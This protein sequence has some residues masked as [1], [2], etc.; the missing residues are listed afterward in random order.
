MLEIKNL[1]F[2]YHKGEA[3]LKDV[4]LT[5]PE[6][7]I[8]VVLGKNGSGKSTLFKNLVGVLNPL[9]GE[10]ILNKLK[11]NEL[12]RRKRAQL[13]SYV[14]Q[15]ISFTSLSVFDS[16][17]LGRIASFGIAS[18]KNDLAI[19]EDIINEMGLSPLA[20]RD[21]S[22]LSGGEAQKVAIARS[23]ALSPS[24]LVFDEPT[25]ALDIG[26]ER[27]ILKEAQKI[28]RHRNLN[29][30]M[31]VHDI[32]LALEYGEIFYFI[33][34]GQLIYQCLRDE[35]T[36]DMINDTFDI[37]AQIVDVMGKKFV[38]LKDEIVNE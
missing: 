33:K 7:M 16:I 21:A 3:V 37:N 5:L 19:V 6:G 30:L 22:S 12:S 13:V 32:N 1:C 25:G 24:L 15:N 18:T 26:N 14:P 20:N 9:K 36:V 34:D 35:V 27:L 28:V 29:I 31:A 2:N 4:S 38:V 17:L 10:I 8:G 23:L 11:L